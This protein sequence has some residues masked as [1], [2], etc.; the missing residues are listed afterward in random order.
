[1][2]SAGL[3][4]GSKEADKIFSLVSIRGDGNIDYSKFGDYVDNLIGHDI[5]QLTKKNNNLM[6][7]G[8]YHMAHRFLIIPWIRPMDWNL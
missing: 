6:L 3:K 7:I 8:H 2:E 5:L 4:F 1:L